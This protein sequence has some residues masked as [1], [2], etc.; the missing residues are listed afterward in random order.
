MKVIR[1]LIANFQ[2]GFFDPE[3]NDSEDPR[4]DALHYPT[5][6]ETLFHGHYMT[7]IS[8]NDIQTYPQDLSRALQRLLQDLK[9]EE[10]LISGF[11]KS[12]LF[13][14]VE[15]RHERLLHAREILAQK[16]S[17]IA[18]YKEVIRIA[19]DELE[20]IMYAFFW[21]YHLDASMSTYIFWTDQQQRF[22]FYISNRGNLHWLDLSEQKIL[23]DTI[24]KEHGFKVGVDI[25]QFL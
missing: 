20:P 5:N 7:M 22:S 23:S 6:S 3:Y 9:C 13:G 1:D 18:G 24:F 11:V 2:Q 10:L 25:N 15:L 4:Y 21:L 16:T 17:S 19:V 12:E 8:H 14:N